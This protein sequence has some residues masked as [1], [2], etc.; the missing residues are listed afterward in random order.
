MREKLLLALAMASILLVLVL[1]A[2]NSY[3]QALTATQA[4]FLTLAE[5][6]V[7]KVH[8]FWWSG[9]HQWFDAQLHHSAVAT[10]WG[11]VPLFEAL[12]GI[13]VADPTPRH[14]SNVIGFANFAE[15]YLNRSLRPVA[16]FAPVPG[17][18][19]SGDTTWF[20]DNG[21]WGLAFL[22]AYQAT[23]K[24]R[25]IG[26]AETAFRFIARSGWDS[27]PRS[28]GGLWWNTKHTFYAGE[29]LAGGTELAARLY[30]ITHKPQFLTEAQKFIAWG[31]QW[32][33]DSSD[34]LYARLR[35]PGGELSPGGVSTQ[36]SAETSSKRYPITATTSSIPPFDPT[37]LPYVQGPMIIANQTLCEAT[38]AHG[39]CVRAE[40][41]AQNA[42]A[43]FPQLEMGPQYDRVY[44]QDMLEL[45]AR[46]GNIAWYRI[47][48]ENA[49][50]ALT[51]AHEGDGLYLKTWDGQPSTTVGS[52]PG[53]LQLDAATISV[54]AWLAA[55]P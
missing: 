23:G 38:G 27:S 32:L 13:A 54:F 47:A 11:I 44:V 21:W 42:A 14:K 34:G 4:R 51:N 52:P 30:A 53:S 29:T 36:T 2:G 28:A 8:R 26:D 24:S 43:R 37:P 19:E 16:G 9:R 25:Y 7:A 39:Y 41:L 6:G 5:N 31:N 3:A 22:D 46:D 35:T 50:R 1:P 15:S 33:W 55:V 18:H 10:L 48:K 45:Y 12:D 17:Q 40:E 20:D 49:L